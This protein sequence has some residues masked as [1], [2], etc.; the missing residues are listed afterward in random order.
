M[1]AKI[2]ADLA[3]STGLSAED[4]D[5]M[6]VCKKSVGEVS[7]NSC[8]SKEEGGDAL[9][10]EEEKKKKKRSKKKKKSKAKKS[11]SFGVVSVHEYNRAMGEDGIPVYG[12][13]PL[14][15][16]PRILTEYTLLGSVVDFE[17]KQQQE[18]Q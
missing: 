7:M 16:G 6:R 12:G 3:K 4:I 18:L 1:L 14:G 10:K 11:V 9:R 15:L 8:N 5:C 13:W 17:K 2:N